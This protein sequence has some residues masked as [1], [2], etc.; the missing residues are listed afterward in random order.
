MSYDAVIVGSGPGGRAV[1]R[2]LAGEGWRVAMIE[3]ELVGGECPFWAC[4]PTKTLLRPVEVQLGARHYP[5]LT[6]AP[7]DWPA[8][9]AYR[10]YMNSGLDDAEKTKAHERMGIEVIHG[11]GRIAGPGVVSVDGRQLETERIVVATGTTSA[12]PT[13]DGLDQ[14]DY[15]TNREATALAD[16]PGSAVVLG[17]GPVGIELAQ[18][19]AG[20]GARVTIVEAADRLVSREEPAASEL[21]ARLLGRD[22]IELR[23]GTI[24]EAV[25]SAARG[26]RVMLSDGAELDAGRLVVAVG[27]APRIDLG[28]EQ[29]GIEPEHHGIEVDERCRAAPGVWAV[30]DVTGVEPFTHVASY[31]GR[32]AAA[33]MAG[34]DSRADYRAVPRVVFCEPQLASVGLTA[35]QAAERGIATEG[36]EV[37]LADLDR[38]ETYGRGLDGKIGV[39]AD[40]RR[41]ILVGAW[42][43]GP[44]AGE[45]IH[46]YALAIKAEVPIDVLRDSVAQ[47]P[48]FSEGLVAAARSLGL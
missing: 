22:G 48:T 8:I 19:L 18:L 17:G 1:A 30:G 11:D 32:I 14:V 13:I 44:I 42:A 29:V 40:R 20:F 4:I 12:I 31:Q 21:L 28:L 25:E 2:T 47:F 37:D 7:V 3:R 5:G 24:A 26:V 6:P 45:W 43:I 15:W 23:L 36:G 39:L 9:A 16:V 10:D 27:R 41:R 33:D 35:A 34:R 46:P 38:T